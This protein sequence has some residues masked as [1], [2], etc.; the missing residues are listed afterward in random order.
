M[1]LIDVPYTINFVLPSLGAKPVFTPTP[2]AAAKSNSRLSTIIKRALALTLAP[3]S[4]L[5]AKFKLLPNVADGSGDAHDYYLATVL[6]HS[7]YI[8]GRHDTI[9]VINGAPYEF[10]MV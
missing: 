8:W 5:T 10:K 1:R 6:A 3:L 4:P 7:E 9:P 2:S